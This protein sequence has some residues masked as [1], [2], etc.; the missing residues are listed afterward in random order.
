MPFF[1]YLAPEAP[2]ERAISAKR[3]RD[4]FPDLR[5]PRGP[6]FNEPDI[7]DKATLSNFPP[8]GEGMIATI[9]ARYGRMVRS[10]QAV[11]EL[12]DRLVTLL[13]ELEVL[14]HTYLIYTSDNGFHFGE[15]RIVANKATPF[16]EG[17]RVPFVVRGPGIARGRTTSSLAANVDIHPTVLDL[18]G[19]RVGPGVDGRS[20]VPLWSEGA[21]GGQPRTAFLLE[22]N[23]LGRTPGIPRF[24]AIRT[25]R[26]KLI[27]YRTGARELYDLQNDP[28]ELENIYESS[29]PLI[30]D[31]LSKRLRALQLCIG[32]RCEQ[33]ENEPFTA[34]DLADPAHP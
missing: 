8:I 16:E 4:L 15:H 11:D 30:R 28:Y 19:E 7:S 21:D 31:E 27:E 23:H 22:S 20:L 2:H 12:V 34:A 3:H 24:T 6:S 25:S 1:L 26:F 14:D 18:V 32:K 33:L 10:L 13:D 17:I 5:A 29:D 9:D